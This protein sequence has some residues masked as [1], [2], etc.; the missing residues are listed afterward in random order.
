MFS[1]ACS[2]LSLNW[3]IRPRSPNGVTV[4]KI[5]ISSACS[6]TCDC[7]NKIERDGSIPEA[8]SSAVSPITRSLISAGW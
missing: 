4:D 8:I 7:T 1:G 3:V 2:L 6:G 5:H